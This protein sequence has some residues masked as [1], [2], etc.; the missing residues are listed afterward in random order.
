MGS[1]CH[2]PGSGAASASCSHDYLAPR[3][4]SAHPLLT[5]CRRP[6]PLGLVATHGAWGAGV[7][8][9][10]LP[11]GLAILPSSPGAPGSGVLFPSPR[12][13]RL[14]VCPG[15]IPEPLLCSL[16]L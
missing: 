13:G 1:C 5:S 15:S 10:R 9:E 12:P 2:H 6:R 3:K 14:R 4:H 8:L 16:L 11:E 7:L